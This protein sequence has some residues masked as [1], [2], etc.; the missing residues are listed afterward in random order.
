IQINTRYPVYIGTRG[1]YHAKI[2]DKLSK[3]GFKKIIPATPKLDRLLRNAYLEKYFVSLGRE[4]LKI[5]M[6]EESAD[7][8]N[9]KE[10]HAANRI[11]VV[12]SAL[13]RPLE[14]EYRPADYERV[15]QA[16]AELT[17]ERLY[18]GVLTDNVGDNI[19]AKNRQYCELTAMYWLW[20]YAKEEIVGLAHYRRHFILPDNWAQ[21]MEEH[22]VDVILPTPLYAVPSIAENYKNRH[23]AADWEFM[24]CYLKEHSLED[25]QE[26]EAFFE[27]N[28]YSPC[29][30]FIMRK[31]VL[32]KFCGWLFPI[33]DVAAAH[34]GQKEDGYQNR[35]P[36]FLS[37]RLMTFYFEKNRD[38][39]KMV[40]ADKNFFM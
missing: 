12:Q 24:M 10:G 23:N 35:Y 31:D 16:G 6:L 14:Q 27:G 34:G 7:F 26:A 37:E 29:N 28:L 32:D 1:I 39:Y 36:G 8:G 21:I 3:M 33:L 4:F 40:Y 38:K 11:Y 2:T 17:K 20:K 22:E 13:D 18:P 30:M 25:Y 15:I 5:D 19:S 9:K